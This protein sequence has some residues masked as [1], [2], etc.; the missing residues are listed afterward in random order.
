MKALIL[1]AKNG[2]SD[3]KKNHG[4]QWDRICFISIYIYVNNITYWVFRGRSLCDGLHA[5]DR[6]K[7]D[8]FYRPH[9][10]Y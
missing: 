2:Q 3:F 1:G 5:P 10:A 4:Y 9:A 8:G 7:C 6:V